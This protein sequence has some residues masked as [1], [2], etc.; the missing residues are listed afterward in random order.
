MARDSDRPRLELPGGRRGG[1]HLSHRRG[2]LAAADR[3]GAIGATAVQLF[4]DNPTSWRRRPEPP[5]DVDAFRARLAELDIAPLAVHAPYLIN[6]AGSDEEFYRRSIEVLTSEMTVAR[7]FGARFLNVHV[8]SH[9]GAGREA[10][11]TRVVD[12][13]AAVIDAGDGAVP[14]PLLVLENGSGGG[15]GLGAR[16]EDLASL[17]DAA[18]SR[19]LDGRI[20]FCIDAAHL[21]GAGYDISHPSGVDSVIARFDELVGIDRLRMIHFNDSVSALGSRQ[22]RH[23]HVAAGQIGA[24]GMARLLTHPALDGAV[25][26][27]ETPHMEH[28]FDEVNLRRM[29]DLAAG[30]KPRPLPPEPEDPGGRSEDLRESGH[31]LRPQAEPRAARW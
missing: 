26:Y 20:G 2:L 4:T 16:L 10:G 3:A 28:G 14:D 8:G 21:W 11:L 5:P 22:D 13:L 9:R 24:P 27:L 7:A 29:E 1:P 15:F 30:R 6:L 17:L 18:G 23:T 19:G 25:Y 31:G 12:A